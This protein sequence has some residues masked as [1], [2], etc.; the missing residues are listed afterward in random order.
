MEVFPRKHERGDSR[1]QA[2]TLSENA[3]TVRE[4]LKLPPEERT[5]LMEES[6]TAMLEVMQKSCA[7]EYDNITEMY[8]ALRGEQL[9]VRREDPT[10]VINMVANDE[11]IEIG[12]PE[13]ERYSGP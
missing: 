9:F 3:L 13:G 10:R 12:F 11:P 4:F 6:S 1:N 8:R 7:A 2:H 5:R